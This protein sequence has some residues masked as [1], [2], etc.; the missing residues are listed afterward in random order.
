MKKFSAAILALAY[1]TAYS[2]ASIDLHYCMGK[3]MSWDLMQKQKSKCSTCGM[4][5]KS[6][7]GCCKDEHKVL[8]IDKDQKASESVF[9]SLKIF[10][11]AV[12]AT[13]DEL[14]LAHPS[15]IILENPASNSPP[16]LTGPPI[17]IL[18]CNFRI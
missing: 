4:D 5:K 2:G 3:L 6:Q 18:N 12:S 15:S 1:L 7:K 11:D 9:Q 16:P 13:Y 14:P 17:F 8:Q 10:S